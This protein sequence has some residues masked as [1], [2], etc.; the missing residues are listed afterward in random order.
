MN[1][2]DNIL[3][4]V[5]AACEKAAA[6]IQS[7]KGQV[8]NDN[9]ET[10]SLNSL[11]SYVDKTSETMLIEALSAIIP[12]STFLSEEGMTEQSEGEYQWI[13]DPLDGTTN[14]LHDI[15][16]FAISV[17]LRHHGEIVLG[18]VLEV[19]RMECF[20]A[21]KNGGAFLNQQPILVKNNAVL[22]DALIATGFPYYDFEILE[23]YIAFLQSLMTSTR[24]IRRLG[25]A[26]VDLCYVACGRF[27]VF[28]EHSLAPW[29]VAAGALIVKEAR[30]F[31]SDFKGESDWLFGRNIVAGT[32]GLQQE[33]MSK[34]QQYQL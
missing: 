13:I 33:F 24:G 1:L 17:A 12:G 11:V 34:I 22:G 14:F 26:A 18:V 20:T 21:I 16:V 31:V 25:A 2:K 30:G 15:P 32:T 4:E 5:V 8:G 29:D 7:A 9:I 3:P 10:K 6:F 28:Y 19:N 27:D 23:K